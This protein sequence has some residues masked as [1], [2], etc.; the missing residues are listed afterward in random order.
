MRIQGRRMRLAKR[1]LNIREI[2]ITME[3][4]MRNLSCR[5]L[6]EKAR[7]KTIMQT[8]CISNEQQA[9]GEGRTLAQNS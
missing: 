8:D 6:L 9:I 1:F 7:A 4:R 3:L 5:S 2:G